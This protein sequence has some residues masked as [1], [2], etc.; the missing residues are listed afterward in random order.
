MEYITHVETNKRTLFWTFIRYIRYAMSF[1]CLNMQKKTGKQQ[2]KYTVAVC[3]IF[4]NESV[5]LKEWLEYHLLIGVEHFYLYNNFSE[6]NYQTSLLLYRERTSH[7]DGM[8]RTIRPT[9]G[10]QRLFPKSKR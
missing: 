3:A 9:A 10:L 2:K 8:A 5:F 7:P 4:K 6:D 1:L